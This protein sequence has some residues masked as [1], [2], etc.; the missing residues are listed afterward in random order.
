MKSISLLEFLC[1]FFLAQLFST[2][3]GFRKN[4]RWCIKTFDEQQKRFWMQ[5]RWIVNCLQCIILLLMRIESCP[6]HFNIDCLARQLTA[7]WDWLM[8]NQRIASTL[9]FWFTHY[10][11]HATKWKILATRASREE[12]LTLFELFSCLFLFSSMLFIAFLETS[13]QILR[14]RRWK[15]VKELCWTFLLRENVFKISFCVLLAN[16]VSFMQKCASLFNHPRRYAPN[17]R[18]Q[19]FISDSQSAKNFSS[20]RFC[21]LLHWIVDACNM[22]EERTLWPS[23]I[24][25]VFSSLL[26]IALG[27][28]MGRQIEKYNCI[29]PGLKSRTYMARCTRNFI[30]IAFDSTHVN[31]DGEHACGVKQTTSIFV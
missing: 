9:V 3:N 20:R 21:F 28:F 29:S 15:C 4:S 27:E 31:E 6:H 17:S 22:K 30:F 16:V 5:F 8:A 1:T 11:S 26:C 2:S 25:Q 23:N 18:H 10:V 14:S 12:G 7:I 24:T 19:H 13:S